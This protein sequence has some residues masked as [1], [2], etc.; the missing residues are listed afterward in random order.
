MVNLIQSCGFWLSTIALDGE[1]FI[2]TAFHTGRFQNRH[3]DE[4]IHL[5]LPKRV[6]F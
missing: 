1:I 4:N 5:G 3:K 6:D 2:P